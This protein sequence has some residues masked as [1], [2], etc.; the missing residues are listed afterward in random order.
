MKEK[1]LKALIEVSSE[2]GRKIGGIY[3]VLRS[4][5]KHLHKKFKQNYLFIGYLDEKCYEE[6][7]FIE[8]EKEY[9]KIFH[10]LEEEGVKCKLGIWNYADE[11]R[12][13]LVDAKIAAEK[14]VEYHNGEK[15]LTDKQINYFKYLLWKH[16][17]IDS[18]MEKSWDFE[19]N[20]RWCFGV[21]KLIEKLF[22]NEIFKKEETI[23]QFHEWIA[24]AALLYCKIKNLEVPTVFTTHATVL[25]RTLVSN[26]VDLY[27]EIKRAKEPISLNVAYT[28]R[29]EGKHQ[30]EKAAALQSTIFTT[31]SESVAEEVGYILGRKPDIITTN[32]IEYKVGEIDSKMKTYL[33]KETKQF[34]EA[35]F[36]GYYK[37]NYDDAL[38]VYISGRYE[39]HNK[40]F[41]VFIKALG[42][43]NQ[44]LKKS[45]KKRKIFAFI[46]APT[47]VKGPK[48]P[49]I[50]NYLL[51]DKITEVLGEMREMKKIKYRN[52]QDTIKQIKNGRR[53][54]IENM[55]KGFTKESDLPPIN[56]YELN[57]QDDAI[58]KECLNNGLDNREENAVKVIFY[59]TYIKPN[60]GLI[61]LNYY[62]VICAMDVGVFPSFYEPFGYTPVEAAISKNIAI[63]S[64]LSGFGKYMQKK[65]K[66]KDSGI[67]ILKMAGKKVEEIAK[68]L[69]AELERIYNL[70][71]QKLIKEKINASKTIKCLDWKILIKNYFTAYNLAMKKLEIKS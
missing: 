13:I 22:E 25:G 4:K 61:N 40:G 52:L 70:S 21:G 19:E 24:G 51:L 33:R 7:S 2:A 27:E 50:K 28:N 38:L 5:A 53:I 39:F 15:K 45:K 16:F 23:I 41:D 18:L 42:L 54:D 35:C 8:P 68:D 43:L 69:S 37:Q 55:K 46:F 49:I 58:I 59:P 36:I 66:R 30:I 62:D 26:G 67:I 10:E 12:I 71:D 47:S 14:I 60:D 1:K 29:V 63:S 48:I 56:C 9:A 3:T 44:K 11:T 32:G 6:V 65:I 34:L 64:D 31:V 17:G 20:V 57:Y